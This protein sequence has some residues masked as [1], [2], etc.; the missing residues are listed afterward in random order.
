K[1]P[2]PPEE[3][4]FSATFYNEVYKGTSLR[5]IEQEAEK[6]APMLDR[7]VLPWLPTDR[8]SEIYEVACG[9]GMVLRWLRQHGYNNVSASDASASQIELARGVGFR[10]KVGDSL[11]ELRDAPA[12]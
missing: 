5:L 12:L 8:N 1:S 11:H 3:K 7:I 2:F 10:V 9:S 6:L 4:P